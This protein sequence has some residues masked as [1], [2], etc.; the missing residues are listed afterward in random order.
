MEVEAVQ[1]HRAM[2][3]EFSSYFI[4]YKFVHYIDIRFQNLNRI[5]YQHQL[6]EQVRAL[7]LVSV[8][9]ASFNIFLM[10]MK[11]SHI[12]AFS[13]LSDLFQ[14][15]ILSRTSFVGISES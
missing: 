1:L 13:Y 12:I 6:I 9:A 11:F 14:K 15:P 7:I 8:L 4:L 3:F 5:R 10:V 2:Q